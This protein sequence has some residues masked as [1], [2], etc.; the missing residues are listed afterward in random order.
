MIGGRR[1][2]GERQPLARG[3]A[4]LL[5]WS[6]GI[7]IE[8]RD[9]LIGGVAELADME[10]VD[11][12]VLVGIARNGGP[13]EHSRLAE[14]LRAIADGEN[15]LALY[16]HAAQEHG[17]RRGDFVVAGGADVLVDEAHL[18][19]FGKVGGN[20]EKTL[21]RHEGA[22]PAA[23]RIGVFERPK[24]RAISRENAKYVPPVLGNRRHHSRALLRRLGRRLNETLVRCRWFIEN[25]RG[26]GPHADRATSL[27]YRN[28]GTRP[29]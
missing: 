19:I 7:A 4:D 16:V 29:L 6:H 26:K 10:I 11:A 13:A 14:A 5:R 27:A 25:R 3:E 2:V 20:G 21:R 28:G 15:V 12:A 1:E 23:Q 9:Q 17:I 8:P 24:G 18:P 22:R